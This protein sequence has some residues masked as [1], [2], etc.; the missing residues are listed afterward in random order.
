MLLQE[1][2]EG[3]DSLVQLGL[4]HEQQHQELL[5]MDLLAVSRGGPPVT[6]TFYT[7]FLLAVSRGWPPVTTPRA[8]TKKTTG[9]FHLVVMQY[10]ID[11][12]ANLVLLFTFL[13]MVLTT[14][15]Y[16]DRCWTF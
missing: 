10:F 5:L 12:I 16:R 3:I 2:P 13:K 11:G 9:A 1:P 14:Y 15:L 4:Q 8:R 6:A 7:I